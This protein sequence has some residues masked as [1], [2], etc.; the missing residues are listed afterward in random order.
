MFRFVADFSDFHA[1]TTKDAGLKRD[2][3]LG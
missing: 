3:P 1:P 2:S